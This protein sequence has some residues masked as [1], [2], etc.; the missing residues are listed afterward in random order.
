M[1]LATILLGIAVWGWRRSTEDKPYLRT[2]KD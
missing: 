1:P 2:D